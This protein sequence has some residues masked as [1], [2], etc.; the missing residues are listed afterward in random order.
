ML[1]V[2]ESLSKRSFTISSAGA[3]YAQS[4]NLCA[5]KTFDKLFLSCSRSLIQISQDDEEYAVVVSH[6]LLLKRKERDTTIL[7]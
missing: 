2:T 5:F 4:F 7:R 1:G 3:V 6:R